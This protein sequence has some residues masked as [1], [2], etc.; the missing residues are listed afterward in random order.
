MPI[1]SLALPRRLAIALG[2]VALIL[3]LLLVALAAF[4][5]GVFRETIE[6]RLGDSVGRPVTIASVERTDAF[7]FTP[8][9]RIRDVTVPQPQGI[10][11]DA[12]ARIAETRVT[13]SAWAVLRGAFRPLAI[14]ASGV[15]LAL[16]RDAQGNRNWTRKAPGEGGGGG[17]TGLRNLTLREVTVD[18]RD[19][20]RKR[21]FGVALTSDT[22][23]GLRIAGTGTVRDTPVR[24]TA[25]APAIGTGQGKPWPFEALIDGPALRFAARGTMDRPLDTRHMTLAID[26]RANDLKLIDAIVEAGLFGTQSVAL[27]AQ[28]HRDG[29]DW[30]ITGLTGTI[31]AS[32]IEGRV[33]VAKREGRTRLDGAVDARNFAFDDLASDEGKAKAAALRREIGPRVVP[34]TRI[35]IAKIDKTDGS[36]DLRIHSFAGE[37]GKAIRGLR[38]TLAIDR[39]LLT[40]TGL[41]IDLARGM[42]SGE[43][44]V[45]QRHGA[46]VPNVTLNLRLADSSIDALANDGTI[47][48]RLDGRITLTGRGNTIREAVANGSGRIGLI[49][50]N[51][52]LPQKLAAMMGFD[53]AGALLASEDERAG[54]RCM[55][56]GLSLRSGV[57]SADPLLIDTTRSQARGTGNVRFPQETIAFTL[58]GAPKT[59][60]AIRLPGSATVHGTISS[61]QVTV[62]EETK[63]IGNVLKGLGRAITGRDGPRP[64]DADCAALS[65]RVLR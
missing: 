26:T 33:R 56:L 5:W 53:V 57:G 17:L 2:V 62:P 18:Y 4:P 31:G 32:R 47:D 20:K 61:P 44:R 54:L 51:G 12:L 46:D 60:G 52:T 34:N 55:A 16:V 9:V 28:A 39:Q 41:R 8:T 7:S 40:L 27:K 48:G 23:N 63:S 24:V 49:A 15:R 30:D 22:T 35:N 50:R 58:T 29:D 3:A 37:T 25:S 1:R 6:R 11:G 14:D 45:D 64:T 19:D 38:G 36:I 13:F 42:L 43:M 65:R 10:S 21:R 59:S